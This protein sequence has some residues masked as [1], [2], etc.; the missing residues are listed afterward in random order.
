MANLLE[1]VG[2]LVN[3]LA[4][5]PNDPILAAAFQRLSISTGAI[6]TLRRRTPR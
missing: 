5:L 3:A 1:V 4:M 2:V 6:T